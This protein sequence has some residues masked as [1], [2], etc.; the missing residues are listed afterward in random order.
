MIPLIQRE[1]TEK[2][3][4]ISDGD[5]IEVIAI[6]ESTPGPIAINVATFVGYRAGGFLGAAFAT[7]GVVLPAFL[8]ILAVAFVL[9]EF[10][11]LRIVRYAFNGIRAGVLALIV[12]AVWTMYRQ[13]RGRRFS[14]VIALAAFIAAAFLGIEVLLILAACAAA[15]LA[16]SALRAGRAKR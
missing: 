3:G 6:A 11:Q 7:L 15:G 10:Q 8:I 9:R 5:L 14:D 16:W 1:A 2:H 12:K 13:C 4:W